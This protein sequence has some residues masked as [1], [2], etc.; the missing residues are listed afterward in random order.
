M[1]KELFIENYRNAFGD[2]ELPVVFWYSDQPVATPEKMRGCFMGQLKLAREGKFVSLSTDEITCPGGKVY[3]G[4]T[5]VPSFL[6]G[7]VSGKER[8]KETPEQVTNFIE[9]LNMTDQSGTFLNFVSLDRVDDFSSVEGV[10]FFA[11][12]DVLSG[13]ISWAFFDTNKSDAVSALFGSGCSA[14]VAQVVVENRKNGYRSFLGMF[15]PSVRPQ[16]EANILTL[17][18]PMSR[19]RKMSSTISESCLQGTHAWKKVKQR[20][21]DGV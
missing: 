1:D 15:D 17:G 11:T 18:V 14:N 12:P 2:Y 21:V 9:D 10:I 19:F 4:F 7:Y 20:I 3:T 8:Y 5:D 13:L 6:P 16:V